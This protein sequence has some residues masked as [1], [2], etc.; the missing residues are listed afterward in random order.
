[1]AEGLGKLIHVESRMEFPLSLGPQTSIGRKDPVT[2]IYPDVDLTP[3]D[4]Q[5]SVSRR[6]AKIHRRGSKFFAA[7]EIGTMNSTFVNGSRLDTGIPAEIRP[8]DE[9]RFG[10][11]V[12]RFESP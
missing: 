8:G 9:L 1:V 3:V 4:T 5:R 7:E 12:M 6:H 11:V 2:G 10:M